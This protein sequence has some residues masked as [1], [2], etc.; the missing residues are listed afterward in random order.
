MH[1]KGRWTK[2]KNLKAIAALD[3]QGTGTVQRASFVE[4]YK[5]NLK[6]TDD[7]GFEKGIQKFFGSAKSVAV[8]K[9]KKLAQ[10]KVD[11]GTVQF[12][13][14]LKRLQHGTIS[15]VLRNWYVNF[16]ISIAI[17]R[18]KREAALQVE[19]KTEGSAYPNFKRTGSGLYAFEIEVT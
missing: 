13:Q 18:V 17:G 3:R 12:R 15:S 11:A 8:E 14:V 4:Y 16:S 9:A 2:E 10:D 19:P 1:P 6:G 5:N 7:K